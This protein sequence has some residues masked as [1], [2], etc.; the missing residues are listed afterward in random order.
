MINNGSVGAFGAGR[1]INITKTTAP[2]AFSYSFTT[3][4]GY[5]H[6]HAVAMT[7]PFFWSINMDIHRIRKNISP[8]LYKQKIEY[9]KNLCNIDIGDYIEKRILLPLKL[10]ENFNKYFILESVNRQRLQN[11]PVDL[12]DF[13][14]L[15]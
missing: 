9:L 1:D 13:S 8:S 7:F 14:E 5:P 15:F 11:N 12:D 6:G 10:P 3:Y 2:H 4:Y